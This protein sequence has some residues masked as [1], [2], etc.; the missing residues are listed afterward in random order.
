MKKNCSSNDSCC[1]VAGGQRQRL[2]IA[3]ALY[4]KAPCTFLDSPF[5]ALDADV[6][7]HVFNVGVLKILMKRKRTVVLASDRLDFA[8]KADKIVFLREGQVEAQVR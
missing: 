5:A 1:S 2:A 3:R 6:A 4:S 7:S 8:E